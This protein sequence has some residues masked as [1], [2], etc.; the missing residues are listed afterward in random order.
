[1]M[2]KNE[3]MALAMT[4]YN[5][6][7]YLDEQLDSL[8]LQNV[9]FDEV[10]I[11]DDCSTDGT[12]QRVEEYIRKYDL[13]TWKLYRHE[14][15]EGFISAFR[16]ALS[17]CDKELIFLCDQDDVWYP[18]K[19]ETIGEVFARHPEL[20]VLATS[21]DLI[22]ENGERIADKPMAKRMNHNLIR[23][24]LEPGAFS[25]LSFDD[26][27]GYNV[28]PGCTLALRRS[29]RNQYLTT[30]PDM[31]LPHD[32][33]MCV[34]AGVGNG[35]GYLDMPLMGYRQHSSNTLGLKRRSTYEERVKAARIDARQKDAIAVLARSFNAPAPSIRKAEDVAQFFAQ[36]VEALEERSIF[37][38][39]SL[40]VSST[41]S[42]FR[43]TIGMDIRTVMAY[44][45]GS[46]KK[47]E[48]SQTNAA[49]TQAKAA[50]KAEDKTESSIPNQESK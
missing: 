3:T 12:P 19:T 20:Q 17:Y 36:R 23:R 1:M 11:V 42:G 8:R 31:T 9:P 28:S 21:F 22:D 26:V 4:T 39:T 45:G 44:K 6:G 2:S 37:E 49:E 10:V 27:I 38:L 41:G 48:P 34:I 40:L 32:W 15:N 50:E 5:A 13:K 35:L 43:L 7:A 16:D 25:W 46:A 18:E 29:L 30:P 47:D 24:P 14:K 33:A